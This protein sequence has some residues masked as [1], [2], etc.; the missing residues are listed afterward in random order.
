MA[1]D[2]SLAFV[3]APAWRPQLS[4]RTAAF[5]A[6]LGLLALFVIYPIYLLIQD[7]FTVVRPGGG[8]VF[9]FDNWLKVWSEP[10]LVQ[11]VVNT[12]YRAVVTIGISLPLAILL[13][14]L[15]ARTD[16]PGKGFII[17]CAWVAYF[18]PTL[19][20]L[21][22]WILLLDPQYGLLN[23]LLKSWFGLAAAPFN[24]YSF[25]GIIFAHLMTKAVA[26][27]FIFLIP[28]FRNISSSL[29]EASR[30]SGAGTFYTLRK[31]VVPVL[32]PAILITLVISLISSLE[33][34]EIELILGTP[35][36]FHVFSTKIYQLIRDDP[37]ALG[38]ATVLGV[39]ILVGMLPLIVLQRAI[40]LK[41]NYV[42]FNSAFKSDP[43][44]L[45]QWRWTI[46]G[47]VGL[48]SLCL[49]VVPLVFLMV[50]TFMK[51]FGYFE[52]AEPYTLRHWQRVL[53]DSQF[54]GAVAN[55]L[56]LGLWASGIGT[57]LAAVIAYVSV[58]SKFRW[59]GAIDTLTWL[60]ASIPGVILGLGL[61]AM[62][63]RLPLFSPFYGTIGVLIVAVLFASLTTGTQLIKS[64]L[65]QLGADL[66]EASTLAGASWLYTF[67]RIVLPLVGGAL[68]SVAVLIF[69]S[70]TRNVANIAMLV[71]NQNKPL[72]MLQI[73]YMA[74]GIFEAAS[75][76]GVI[77]VLITCGVAG[78]VFWLGKRL[79]LRI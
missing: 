32:L 13:A 26:I 65:I 62:F 77:T 14:W 6:L 73:D 69:A 51:A 37:P 75:I 21:L 45:R 19:P 60:P 23:K 24:I 72:S 3:A 63:L 46:F 61:L 43:L 12:V 66:E 4:G 42:T 44:R 39:S 17:G 22:G 71:T 48:F 58:R 20:V 50:G 36:N 2:P 70:A 7:S 16:M 54:L 57:L 47:G 64:N 9:A 28:A 34:F 11:A 56:E 74:D 29:E 1:Q 67:R 31:I 18:M 8:E 38:Q 35:W 33:S 52:L 79:G 78:A 27:K 41:R 49:T 68:V 59:R 25:W 5:Y 55:T 40:S 30:I 10:G 15:V 53:N 76:V